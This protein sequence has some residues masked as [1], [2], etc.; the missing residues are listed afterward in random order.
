MDPISLNIVPTIIAPQEDYFSDDL[1]PREPEFFGLD[2]IL[3]YIPTEDPSHFQPE[4]EPLSIPDDHTESTSAEQSLIAN[5]PEEFFG[6]DQETNSSTVCRADAW[7]EAGIIDS[8]PKIV[9]KFNSLYTNDEL[10]TNLATEKWSLAEVSCFYDG[11]DFQEVD[12]HTLS[13]GLTPNTYYFGKLKSEQ[14][15]RF[16]NRASI[17]SCRQLQSTDCQEHHDSYCIATPGGIVV[18]GRNGKLKGKLEGDIKKLVQGDSLYIRKLQELTGKNFLIL[19]S[20]Q[21]VSREKYLQEEELE[22]IVLEKTSP[23]EFESTSPPF[24]K[25]VTVTNNSQEF[26]VY[27]GGAT[28]SYARSMSKPHVF[29]KLHSS[30]LDN[31]KTLFWILDEKSKSGP[32]LGPPPAKKKKEMINFVFG[33]KMTRY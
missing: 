1:P 10:D 19:Y 14:K 26:E 32:H 17:E 20:H 22:N 7:R 11:N 8:I 29:W 25:K 15:F 24:K 23:F 18:D 33:V 13:I 16:L 4:N 5:A 21:P 31:K 28:K 2:D 12:N 3:F 9:T 27:M 6:D 30:K